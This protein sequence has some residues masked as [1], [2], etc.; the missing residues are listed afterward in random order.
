MT[1]P[2]F[3]D[4][5]GPLHPGDAAVAFLIL[6]DGR[7]LMQCR[8]RVPE[9]FYP[10][11]W[12]FFGGAMRPGESDLDALVREIDEEL[13]YAF[14]PALATYFTTLSFDL[15]FAGL[16]TVRRVFFEV[17]IS[18]ARV[19]QLELSEGRDMGVF[20]GRDLLLNH[21]V[22]PYDAFALWLHLRGHRIR[23]R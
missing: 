20:D 9:I 23:A 2:L 5:S 21:P 18:S 6:E 1:D 13:S 11:H 17:P 16:G 22:A 4:A 10:D 7:Y 12:S 19:P 3:L 14:D 15:G 8:D